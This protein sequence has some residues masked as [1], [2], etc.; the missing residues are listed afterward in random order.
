MKLMA[1]HSITSSARANTVAGTLRP[2]TS[3]PGYG[4]GIDVARHAHPDLAIE[5]DRDLRRRFF[6]G[7][8]NFIRSVGQAV[9]VDV[10]TY[11]ASDTAHV[12]A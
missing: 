6:N 2:D 7:S 5:L 1:I 3:L 4:S 8:L 10:Y 9:C 11:A 12:L